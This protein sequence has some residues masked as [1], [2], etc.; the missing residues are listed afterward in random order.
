MD[1]DIPI[2]QVHVYLPVYLPTYTPYDF[3]LRRTNV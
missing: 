2:F 1:F 3:L